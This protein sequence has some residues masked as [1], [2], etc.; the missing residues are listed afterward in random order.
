MLRTQRKKSGLYQKELAALLP[1]AGHSR[2]SCVER[3]LRRPNADEI[4]A[5]ELVFS[6]L[7]RNLFPGVVLEVEEAVLKNAR[8]LRAR[9]A[10]DRSERANQAKAHLKAMLARAAHRPRRAGV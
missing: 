9:L 3:G 7:P 6:T 4:L 1:H 2:V 5:Y 10:K 8:R